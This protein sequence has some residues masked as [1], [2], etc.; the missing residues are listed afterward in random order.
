MSKAK[1][2]ERRDLQISTDHNPLIQLIS[3]IIHISIVL[4]LVS[5]TSKLG[6]E[7]DCT[8]VESPC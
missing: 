8:V 5:K 6:N 4:F 2:N 1:S 7:I 3:T